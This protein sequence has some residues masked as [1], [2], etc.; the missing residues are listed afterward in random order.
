[1]PIFSG[2]KILAVDDGPENLLLIQ[3]FLYETQIELTFAENG[4]EALELCQKNHYDLILMDVQMPLMDGYEA[5][6]SLRRLGQ[7]M[8]IVATTAYGGNIAHDKCLQV[9]FNS[10][11]VKPINKTNLVQTLQ[12]YLG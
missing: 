4:K 12:L 11:L 7:T 3:M 6:E 10:I 9:G 1:M 2:K 8:P 5:T